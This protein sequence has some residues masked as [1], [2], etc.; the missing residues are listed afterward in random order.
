MK[1]SRAPSPVSIVRDIYLDGPAGCRGCGRSPSPARAEPWAR[2][3]GWRLGVNKVSGWD[4]KSQ[5]FSFFHLMTEDLTGRVH[6][7]VKLQSLCSAPCR[8][9]VHRTLGALRRV[10]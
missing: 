8:W 2:G 5:T 7:E 3:E 9:K 6:L 4:D 10:I 1:I